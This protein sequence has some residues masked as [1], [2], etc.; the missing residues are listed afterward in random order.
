MLSR[1]SRR[2]PPRVLPSRDG[3]AAVLRRFLRLHA[4]EKLP[5]EKGTRV[6]RVDAALG[7]WEAYKFWSAQK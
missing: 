7:V 5:A 3:A 6:V 4:A 2:V 1:A